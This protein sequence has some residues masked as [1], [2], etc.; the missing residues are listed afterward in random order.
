[1]KLDIY[2]VNKDTGVRINST[3]PDYSTLIN[4]ADGNFIFPNATAGTNYEFHLTSPT[5]TTVSGHYY[6]E[7]FIRSDY[8]I[9]LKY[10][11]PNLLGFIIDQSASHSDVIVIR[12]KEFLGINSMSPN[13]DSLKLNGTELCAGVLTA[14]GVLG[15]PIALFIFDKGSDGVSDLSGPINSGIVSTLPFVAGLDFYM[16]AANP[17]DSPIPIVLNGRKFSNNTNGQRPQLA[18]N[19]RYYHGSVDGLLTCHP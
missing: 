7:P 8:L 6:Y 5:D 10:I 3:T 17:P 11:A 4:Q 9:R 1:M 18:I 13:E 14:T 12:N 15:T 19:G 16:P 2:E